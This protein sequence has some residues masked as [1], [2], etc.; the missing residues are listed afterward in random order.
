[1]RVVSEWLAPLCSC[2]GATTQTSSESSRAIFSKTWMPG[3]RIPSS[4]EIRIRH[5][6]RLIGSAILSD[7]LLSTHIGVQRLGDHDSAVGGLK[8]LEDRDQGAADREPRTV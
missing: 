8:V 2:S 1:R 6:S 3:E 4:F 7:R 5:L